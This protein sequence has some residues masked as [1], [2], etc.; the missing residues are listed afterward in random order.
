MDAELTH[1]IN[2]NRPQKPQINQKQ[3]KE[4]E[5]DVLAKTNN[6]SLEQS[7]LS[8]EQQNLLQEFRQKINS[9][10]VKETLKQSNLQNEQNLNGTNKVQT[11]NLE[12]NN[13]YGMV[14]ASL[15][16]SI[17]IPLNAED[18]LIQENKLY[19]ILDN[20]RVQLNFNFVAEEYLEFSHISS[21]QTLEIFFKDPK[22]KKIITNSQIFEYTAAMLSVFVYMKGM[23]TLSTVEHLKNILYYCHQNLI[24]TIELMLK[25]I[26]FDYKDNIWVKKLLEIVKEKKSHTNKGKNE[27]VIEQNNNILF[28]CIGNFILLYFN[29]K[30]DIRT[31]SVLNDIMCNIDR[32]SLESVKNNY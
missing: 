30:A 10:T 16:D 17:R 15:E 32:C 18:L 26:C 19:K 6:K 14:M 25:N 21:L 7:Q 4:Q 1:N 23:L 31:F 5:Q 27:V 8:Q 9:E 2:T 20:I 22:L 24:L 3:N 12:P 29:N 13:E 28:N 11:E